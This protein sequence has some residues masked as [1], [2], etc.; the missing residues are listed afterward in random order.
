M[1]TLP[2]KSKPQFTPCKQE[3]TPS[4]PG[5]TM[6]LDME[7][8]ETISSKEEQLITSDNLTISKTAL[9]SKTGYVIL[10]T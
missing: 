5:F 8:P 10:C 9:T 1:S 3:L 2:G 6:G 7:Q 4:Q